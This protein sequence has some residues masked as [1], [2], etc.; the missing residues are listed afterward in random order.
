MIANSFRDS[1]VPVDLK[2]RYYNLV[3]SRAKKT[4]QTVESNG[5]FPTYSALSKILPDVK[6]NA[7]ELAD[8]AI[9]IKV[10]IVGKRSANTKRK[11]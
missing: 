8:E 2:I 11:P 4:L 7:P 3:L 6:A 1:S 5:L 10:N 9:G